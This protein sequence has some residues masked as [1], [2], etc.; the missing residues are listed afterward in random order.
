MTAMLTDNPTEVG[1]HVFERAGLGKA[2][3]RC[4]AVV[5]KVFR[6]APDAPPQPG[7]TCD[8]CG[9]PLMT[10]F[11]V[12]AADGREF[13]VGCNCIDKSGDKGLIRQYKQSPEYRKHQAEL[14]R[15]RDARVVAEWEALM[16]DPKAT[17]ILGSIIVRRFVYGQPDTQETLLANM[18]RTWNWCGMAGHKRHLDHAKAVIAKGAL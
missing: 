8:F 11:M 14:R 16:A 1:L 4:V 7:A 13:G 12:R 3:Y 10:V 15:N 2:P 17:T 5:E 18:Q 9:T 6:V